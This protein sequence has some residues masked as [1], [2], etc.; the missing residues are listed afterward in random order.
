MFYYR[1]MPGPASEAI[2]GRGFRD[3]GRID[4]V[5]YDN[6]VSFYISKT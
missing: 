1:K 2:E 5:N 6:W 3:R 4:F